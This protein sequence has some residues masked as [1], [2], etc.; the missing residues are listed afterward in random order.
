MW[1]SNEESHVLFT[2]LWKAWFL[3]HVAVGPRLGER[4]MKQVIVWIGLGVLV[5]L[6]A[7][8]SLKTCQDNRSL[9]KSLLASQ[10]ALQTADLEIGRANTKLG[11]ANDLV[12]ELG[13]EIQKEIEERN[14]TAT[15][16]ASV[17]A[18]YAAEARK[19]K[20]KT[21]VVYKDNGV[22]KTID[23]PTGG[24]Y[25]RDDGGGY[26]KINNLPFK[27]KDFRIEIE[28]DLMAR[29]LAY[30]LTQRFRG[31]F[32]ETKLPGGGF[33]HYLEL[34]ELDDKGKE[35]G[36]V[37]L[38]KFNVVKQ[39]K[40]E[41]RFHWFNPKLDL[42]MGYGLN[43]ALE[44]TWVGQVGM[45]FM[46]YGLTHNDLSWKFLRAGVGATRHGLM[47]SFSPVQFNIAKYLPVFSNLWLTPSIGY[48][49][50]REEIMATI[51]IG[52]TL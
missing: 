40:R 25:F 45:S 14:A 26:N 10:S 38:T 1:N 27:F 21:H 13:K 32:V 48:D 12:S 46:S 42:E 50:F 5:A 37:R 18:E 6:L 17:Y 43:G 29:Q 16:L 41:A 2:G 39:D 15:L 35:V 51:G 24:L 30:K 33:N 31:M 11:V 44:H 3:G 36:K 34:W 52:V 49:F 23:L 19:Q 28:G 20:I 9:K 7:G 22:I 4:L 47:T 8:F